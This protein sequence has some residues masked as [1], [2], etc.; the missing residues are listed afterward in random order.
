MVKKFCLALILAGVVQPAIPADVASSTALITPPQPQWSELTIEQRVVLAPLSGDWDAMEA[1][2]QK[3]WLG[4]TRRF[5]TLTPEEQRRIQSQMQEWGKL[6]PEQRRL[7]REN[8]KTANKLPIEKKEVLRQKWE[9]YSSLPP[10]EKERLKEQTAATAARPRVN[11]PVTAPAHSASVPAVPAASTAGATVSPPTPP[12]ESA[13]S[14]GSSPAV[15]ETAP[16]A[17][18]DARR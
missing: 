9:E 18:T 4:I 2:R 5:T 10:E 13:E 12:A 11:P 3:K 6:T 1:H 7:A 15:T 14:R 17:D 16:P 8:F